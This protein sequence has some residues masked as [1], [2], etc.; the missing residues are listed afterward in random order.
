MCPYCVHR[1]LRKCPESTLIECSEEKVNLIEQQPC[2]N[3]FES[4]ISQFG[5][6][7]Y[8]SKN[9]RVCAKCLIIIDMN[10][11]ND[12]LH[13]CDSCSIIYQP[14]KLDSTKI[15]EVCV[16]VGVG[17]DVRNCNQCRQ[18]QPLVLFTHLPAPICD[19]CIS[20]AKNDRLLRNLLS[21]KENER[22][23]RT[24]KHNRD[25]LMF[26]SASE[27]CIDCASKKK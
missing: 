14:V 25:L 4:I 24:G 8:L 20:L 5:Q 2:V 26:T 15:L 18:Q 19:K 7:L 23:C 6:K 1:V 17:V 12:I 10:L 27:M 9:Y 21:L 22:H 11:F 16:G 3:Q 13:M